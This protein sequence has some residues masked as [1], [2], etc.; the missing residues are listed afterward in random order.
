MNLLTRRGGAFW[1]C[2]LPLRWLWWHGGRDVWAL[3]VDWFAVLFRPAWLTRRL[4]RGPMS[5]ARLRVMTRRRLLNGALCRLSFRLRLPISLGRPWHAVIELSNCCNLRCPLCT[6]GGLQATAPHIR[7]GVM[8]LETFQ[9]TID[10]LSPQLWFVELYNWG[11]PF[12]NKALGECIR[13]A[14]SRGILTQISTNMQLYTEALGEQL[15]ACG[16]TKLIVSCDGL[17]QETYEKYRAGGS[18]EKVH[19]S[20]RH[21]LDLRKARGQAYPYVEIQMIV[22]RHNE[23][24][25]AAFKQHWLHQGVDN[26]AFVHMSF[27]SKTGKAVAEAGGF[28]PE[29]QAWPPYHPYGRLQQCD[30]LYRQITVD[31]N[32]C[33]YTCCFPSGETDYSLGSVSEH[34][35]GRIWNGPRYRYFRKLV[36]NKKAYREWHDTMCHDCVGVFPSPAAKRYWL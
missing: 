28:V 10:L 25:M 5:A 8:P 31:W 11:E 19:S 16:L 3:W 21:L 29:S 35:V 22:F 9:R 2:L 34:D 1:H 26:V 7:R 24:E 17:T 30:L 12:L 36:A 33:L 23:N 32:G 20:V 13:Y 27:M 4:G 6:T 14:H 18:L 15:I